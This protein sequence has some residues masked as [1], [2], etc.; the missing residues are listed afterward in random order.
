LSAGLFQEGENRVLRPPNSALVIFGA[1]GDLTQRK[2]LPA[3]YNLAR[4]GYL[5]A[6]YVIIG[7]SRTKLSD[8]DFR[9]RTRKS[10]QDFSRT[11]IEPDI[12]KDFE[13]RLFYQPTDAA[14]FH[15][16]EK[17]KKR[18]DDLDQ[19]GGQSLNLL[20]YLATAPNQF[21]PITA[22]LAAVGL[23]AVL[24]SGPKRSVLV[25]EKPF[26]FDLESAR[27]LNITLQT[28][29]TEEQIYRI[30]HYLG[31]ETVQ[32]ILVFRFANGIFEPLWSR[33]FIDHIQ[34][35]VCE[36]IG[37]GSRASYFD[38]SGI[39]RDIVQNHLLQM[40]ALV[41][42]EPPFSLSDANSIRDEKVKV[43]KSIRRLEEV[44]INNNCIRAQYDRGF[45][46]SKSVN[47]YL[48]EDGVS[49]G[50]KTETYTAMRLEIDNWRWSGVPI[51]IRAGKR[52]PRR[53][54]EIAIYFKAAPQSM[55]K[56]RLI[57][58]LAQN[59]LA[60]QVQPEEGISFCINSKPPGPRLRAKPVLMD[61][62]YHDSFGESSPEAYERL[63]LD[64]MKH[65]PTLFTR[66]DEIEES[67]SLLQPLLERWQDSDIPVYRYESG[68]WGP[69]E[70]QQMLL[71]SGHR[72][73]LL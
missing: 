69:E 41:C 21:A 26:G 5:P 18:L 15:D 16:F 20:F 4:D 72:W 24:A 68:S 19:T 71:E 53:I 52:L 29:F 73:R 27:L 51:Y 39:L 10:I 25:V 17:L 43:L 9:T 8:Q 38:E 67:W 11:A 36:D 62:H 28:H 65:D 32:N 44:D 31:K 58:Q 14:N 56:G 61:F 33:E 55:F 40:L 64:A 70:A 1:T 54:T 34:I 60:I 45:V 50:S 59:Y 37:V 49:T 30:D 57:N 22:N 6:E 47:G 35:S 13:S 2:L 46:Q 48:E 63:L 23:G 42:I 7:A 66:N 3:L 12:W